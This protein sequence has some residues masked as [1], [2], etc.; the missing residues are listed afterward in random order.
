MKKAVKKYLENVFAARQAPA[1]AFGPFFDFLLSCVK[2]DGG[3]WHEIHQY[4]ELGT[5]NG[6][7]FFDKSEVVKWWH[8]AK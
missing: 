5:K 3:T 8:T 6:I 2:D 1:I 7:L 4:F